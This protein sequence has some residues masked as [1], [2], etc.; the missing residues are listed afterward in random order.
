LTF[1]P[2]ALGAFAALTAYSTLPPA[3]AASAIPAIA[4]QLAP[5]V[6][7]RFLVIASEAASISKQYSNELQVNYRRLVVPLE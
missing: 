1:T 7:Q 2:Q 6:G 4:A 3:I 5:L